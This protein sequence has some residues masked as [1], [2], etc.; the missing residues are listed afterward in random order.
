M[1][2]G[3]HPR[4]TTRGHFRDQEEPVTPPWR[5]HS[6]IP[7]WRVRALACAVRRVPQSEGQQPGLEATANRTTMRRC[8][9][10]PRIYGKGPRAVSTLTCSTQASTRVPLGQ[11]PRP[12]TV[13]GSTT[14]PPAVRNSGEKAIDR[15]VLVEWGPRLAYDVLEHVVRVE[16]PELTVMGQRLSTLSDL[17]LTS[18]HSAPHVDVRLRRRVAP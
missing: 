10:Q 13:S 14:H 16:A 7:D 17:Q 5:S 8:R 12:D 1:R 15:R 18:R 2:M 9:H 11:L 3:P 4:M 6:A